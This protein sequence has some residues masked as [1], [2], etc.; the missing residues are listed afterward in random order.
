MAFPPPPFLRYRP[1][2]Y[3]NRLIFAFFEGWESGKTCIPSPRVNIGRRSQLLI[4]KNCKATRKLLITEFSHLRLWTADFLARQGRP[5]PPPHINNYSVSGAWDLS[6]SPGQLRERWGRGRRLDYI[7]LHYK[8]FIAEK[9]I[10]YTIPDYRIHFILLT[11]CKN[12]QLQ[13]LHADRQYSVPLLLPFLPSLSIFRSAHEKQ[14]IRQY[15]RYNLIKTN[16]FPPDV[17][18]QLKLQLGLQ[19]S[20]ATNLTE[21]LICP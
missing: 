6:N 14:N 17:N 11:Q 12:H 19:L 15:M 4:K 2:A 9:T 1:Q 18:I 10:H 21:G 16:I 7:T 20:N 13:L 8:E 5:L 3:E